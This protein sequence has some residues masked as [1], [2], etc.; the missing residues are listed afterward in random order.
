MTTQSSDRETQLLPP[1][2]GAPPQLAKGIEL[3]GVFEG[4]GFKEPPYIA[5]RADGQ[6]IQLPQLLYMVAEEID[7]RR[8]YEEIGARVSERFGR[9]L[10]GEQ[11][12]FLV[13]EKLRPLGVVAQADGST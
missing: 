10:E 6:V 9:R 13:E 1:A 2:D 5:R 12:R 7:G 11:A 3:V 8:S 4:S